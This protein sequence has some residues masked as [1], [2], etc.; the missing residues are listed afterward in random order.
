MRFAAL[1]RRKNQGFKV[2][3]QLISV[4]RFHAIIIDRLGI[5]ASRTARKM[6][7]SVRLGF[8]LPR[9]GVLDRP[10]K[11]IADCG[12]RHQIDAATLLPGPGP[13]PEKALTVSC[14]PDC[15]QIEALGENVEGL[16]HFQEREFRRRTCGSKTRFRANDAFQQALS[17]GSGECSRER[18]SRVA[19]RAGALRKRL[20]FVVV[21]PP[22][23]GFVAPSRS[24]VK[25]RIHAT[26][27]IQ[28]PRLG[29]IGV[30]DD[31]VLEHK[32]A[33]ASAS[34]A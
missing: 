2:T 15:S 3:P 23:T 4:D 33:H 30:V 34:H 28:A 24:A 11:T 27:A 12:L 13:R 8:E 16:F 6:T 14:R 31:A 19:T 17:G 26:E 25:P 22:H 20:V 10:G 21:A 9:R 32:R 1:Q 7:R 18:L 5:E 29:R